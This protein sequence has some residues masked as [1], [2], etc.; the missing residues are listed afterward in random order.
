ML[1]AQAVLQLSK[2]VDDHINP[3]GPTA[4]PIITSTITI[5]AYGARLER[6][7]NQNFRLFTV[8]TTGNLTIRRAYIRGFRAKGGNGGGG[9]GGRGG[10]EL[11]ERF[12]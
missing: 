9:G 3:A 12:S 5:L 11:A 7:G 10:L 6:I 8:G 4:T 2:I 1:P